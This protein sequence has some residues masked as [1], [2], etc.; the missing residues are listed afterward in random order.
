MSDRAYENRARR[1]TGSIAVIVSILLFFA[2]L[3]SVCY[4]ISEVNHDCSGDNCPICN[5][6]GQC[7]SLLRNVSEGTAAVCIVFSNTVFLALTLPALFASLRLTTL[8]TCKV[9][10]ND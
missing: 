10:M 7:E 9:R 6:I 1:R 3:F 8:I 5:Y 2:V 4:V